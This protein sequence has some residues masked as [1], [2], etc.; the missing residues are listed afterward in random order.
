M[1]VSVKQLISPCPLKNDVFVGTDSQCKRI[2]KQLELERWQGHGWQQPYQRMMQHFISHMFLQ[3]SMHLS[4]HEVTPGVPNERYFVGQGSMCFNLAN[5][6][7]LI[8]NQGMQLTRR[9]PPPKDPK[10]RK[11][12][13]NSRRLI[14]GDVLQESGRILKQYTVWVMPTP[15]HVQPTCGGLSHSCT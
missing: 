12:A 3:S 1:I 14:F 10:G 13:R 7:Q 2:Q 8:I 4:H 5:K 6:K 11:G 15:I 9:I